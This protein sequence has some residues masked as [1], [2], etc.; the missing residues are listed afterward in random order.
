MKKYL[1]SR[2]KNDVT[3]LFDN[4]RTSTK[5]SKLNY[6]F[7]YL[8]NIKSGENFFMGVYDFDAHPQRDTNLIL[9]QQ[10]REEDEQVRCYQQIPITVNN[11]NPHKRIIYNCSIFSL[12][13]SL[14]LEGY[15]LSAQRKSRNKRKINYLMGSGMLI[16]SDLFEE[17]GG[18]SNASDDIKTGYYLFFKGEREQIIPVLN[19]VSCVE[20]TTDLINQSVRIA[21]GALSF[22]EVIKH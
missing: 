20:T 12:R 1:Y 16:R 5:S 9:N 13:R 7:K 22:L 14:G 10:L 6:A 21:M 8:L 11:L 17:I 15:N 18:F 2:E 19:K 3:L 4:S